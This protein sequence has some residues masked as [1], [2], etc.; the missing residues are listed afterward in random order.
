MQLPWKTF[1][2]PLG[3]IYKT[4]SMRDDLGAYYEALVSDKLRLQGPTGS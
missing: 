4:A 1:V 2:F 3:K